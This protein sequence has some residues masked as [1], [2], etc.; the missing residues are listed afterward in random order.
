MRATV[1]LNLVSLDQSDWNAGFAISL[2]ESEETFSEWLKDDAD[3]GAQ[4]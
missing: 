4:W 2:D 1:A 3:A